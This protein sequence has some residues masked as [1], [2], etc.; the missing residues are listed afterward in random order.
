[1]NPKIVPSNYVDMVEA[2][3]PEH[4]TIVTASV[5]GSVKWWSLRNLHRYVEH[6]AGGGMMDMG[7]LGSLGPLPDT[8]VGVIK[9]DNVTETRSFLSLD[10]AL[11]WLV[12]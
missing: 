12:E 5:R 1:M 8:Y 4:T 11:H 9:F 10:D 6:F 3:P 7:K 2:F